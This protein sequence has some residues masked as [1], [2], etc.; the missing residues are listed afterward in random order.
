ML[1]KFFHV[2]FPYVNHYEVTQTYVWRQAFPLQQQLAEE[3]RGGE[4][5][6]YYEFGVFRLRSIINFNK[7][8]KWAAWR[9]KAL[10]N[11]RIFAF[12]SFAGLP[13]LAP[14]DVDDPAF[15]KGEYACSLDE[16]KSIAEK[17]NIKDIE[18]IKGYYEDSLTPELAGKMVKAPPS[19]VHIDCDTFSSTMSV[20]RWLDPIALPGALY[21][22]DDLWCYF[23]HPEHGELGAIHTYNADPTTRGMLVEHPLGLGSKKVWMYCP[24]DPEYGVHYATRAQMEALLM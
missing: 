12:D 21:F 14:E 24:R 2:A 1:R 10:R 18:Y 4:L 23:G 6:H 17:N 11:I 19:L 22:F 7:V 8:R 16:V 5:G 20:L 9:N 13:E 15:Y 3:F